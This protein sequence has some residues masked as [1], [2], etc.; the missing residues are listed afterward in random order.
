MKR[1][2]A[3]LSLLVITLFFLLSCG[4]DKDT[5]ETTSD[6]DNVSTDDSLAIPD[7]SESNDT[8]S[9]NTGNSA[10]DTDNANTGDSADDTD[11]ADTGNSASDTDNANT[12]DTSPDEDSGDTGDSASDDDSIDTV[13][14]EDYSELPES[15]TF[16]L[17]GLSLLVEESVELRDSQLILQDDG[18]LVFYSRTDD[19]LW[20]TYTYFDVYTENSFAFQDDG[21]LVVYDKDNTPLWQ[22]HAGGVSVDH[23]TIDGEKLALYDASNTLIWNSLHTT[24]N[25]VTTLLT[26][27][28]SYTVEVGGYF[29]DGDG[30][31]G[32]FKWIANQNRAAADG[33]IIV[34]PSVSL[35]NQGTGSGV[36]CWVR[37]YSGAVNILWF[38]V[39]KT[40]ATDNKAQLLKAFRYATVLIP[41]GVSIK[42][43]PIDHASTLSLEINGV[44]TFSGA[45]QNSAF[46]LQGSGTH[47]HG[48][49][50]VRAENGAD[51]NNVIR[52]YNDDV[53]IEDIEVTAINVVGDPGGSECGYNPGQPDDCHGITYGRGAIFIEGERALIQNCNIHHWFGAALYINKSTNA[54]VLSNYIHDNTLGIFWGNGT[55]LLVDNNR[56][57]HNR[58]ISSPRGV[59][60]GG[61]GIVT[62]A[63]PLPNP[64]P[65]PSD[66]ITFTNNEVAE[67]NEHGTYIHSPNA[68]ITGNNV[69]NNSYQGIKVD[70]P[71]PV[72]IKNNTLSNNDPNHGDGDIYIQARW[73][74]RDITIE[75]N[76]I[77]TLQENKKVSMKAVIYEWN[78]SAGINN[79]KFLNNTTDGYFHVEYTSGFE[80]SGNTYN[81]SYFHQEGHL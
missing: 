22:A 4:T 13:S 5:G 81:G 56:I 63:G 37:V 6:R 50:I 38:G 78:D 31:G 49:G 28:L 29:A 70:C 27:P 23:L 11:N 76:T 33:G 61:S 10:D 1:W 30:G 62:S 42:S 68:T 77:T 20:S 40:G 36:G 66:G 69:H 80:H 26:T 32:I 57:L 12:G 14:D 72:L 79:I 39:D 64:G 60:A 35:A 3:T 44:L 54:R 24:T 55:N 34:D 71:G 73:Q 21:N 15:L 45:P 41:A 75:N 7:E 9:A 48:S 8:D 52:I 51:Y 46:K 53:V 2:N 16:P 59:L 17:D 67:N 58:N 65:S 43:S 19:V 18:N 25:S 47:L 74:M